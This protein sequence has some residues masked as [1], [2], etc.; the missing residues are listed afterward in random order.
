LDDNDFVELHRFSILRAINRLVIMHRQGRHRVSTC[1]EAWSIDLI[2]RR[3]S[4]GAA[5]EI[6]RVLKVFQRTRPSVN[7][8]S[9]LNPQSTPYRYPDFHL[10][11]RGVAPTNNIPEA[12]ERLVLLI[13]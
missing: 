2:D 4:S 1:V 10:T 6:L 12:L 8:E 13:K 11:V 9:I 3:V 5:V 7:V